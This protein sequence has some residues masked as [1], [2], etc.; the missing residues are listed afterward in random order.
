MALAVGAA[1]TA[2][3]QTLSGSDIDRMVRGKT[4]YFDVL[5][6]PTGAG[7][8]PYFFG[9]D[10]QAVI[11]LPNGTVMRGPW[12]IEGDAYCTDWDR[13]P[14]NSCSRLTRE[15]DVIKA[16]N[17]ADGKPRSIVKRLADGNPEKL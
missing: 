16:I 13:G 15:G 8:A 5:P 14:K 2:G 17:P 7:E 4:V 10:G 9:A 3:A 12:R 1:T 11:R 6:G